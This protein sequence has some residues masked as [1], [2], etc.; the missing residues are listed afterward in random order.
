MF[1]RTVCSTQAQLE[2]NNVFHYHPEGNIIN[3]LVLLRLGIY[4]QNKLSGNVV[5]QFKVL[6]RL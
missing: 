4:Y 6:L 5:D 1:F 3:I 2:I